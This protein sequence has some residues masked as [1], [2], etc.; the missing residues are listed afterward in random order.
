MRRWRIRR[1]TLSYP[2]G[3]SLFFV[4]FLVGAV[5]LIYQ[6]SWPNPLVFDS[7]PLS[8]IFSDESRLDAWGRWAD[9]ALY[10]APRWVA[11]KTY[12]WIYHAFGSDTYWQRLANTLFHAL[13]SVFL[14]IFFRRLFALVLDEAVPAGVLHPDRL[15]F[16]SAL[17]FALHPVGV[18]A[19]AYLMQRSTVLATLFG[20]VALLSYLEGLT[21]DKKIWLLAAVGFYY[22]AVFSKEHAL[23]VPA[24]ALSMTLLLQR[25]SRSL[26]RRVWLPFFLFAVI[27]L[28]VVWLQVQQGVVGK[29]YEPLVDIMRGGAGEAAVPTDTET[30]Y[31]L[32]VITQGYLFF[33]YLGLW[34]VPYTGWMAIDLR[35]PLA[36]SYFSWPGTFG[37]VAF[38]AFPIVAAW[39]LLQRGRRGLLGFGLLCPWLL[40]ATEL[41]AVR[42]QEPFVLYRSYLWMWGLFAALPFVAYNVRKVVG[43]VLLCGV[44][45]ILPFLTLE[46]LQTFAS[47]LALWEDA[48][49][50]NEALPDSTLGMFRPYYNRGVAYL[51]L[52]RYPEAIRDLD[53]AIE[54]SPTYAVL[55]SDRATANVQLG[56][57]DEALGDFDK[58]VRLDPERVKS[59]VNRGMLYAMLENYPEALSDFDRAIQIN[60][61]YPVTYFNRAVV[62]REIGDADRAME[63]FRVSCDLGFEEACRQ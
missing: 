40:F 1:P 46:R 9:P 19:T 53:K 31:G 17:I 49:E 25:P 42:L 37:F 61:K 26:V 8:N 47:E 10:A 28:G 13:T 4:A 38:C 63:D 52:G 27:A 59:Y 45:L 36:T 43:M 30:L 55:Y 12:Y 3:T 50:K 24:V 39:L 48:V 18:Y 29:V 34:L 11:A 41:A 20:V 58:A 5:V 54:L 22:L 23:M 33:K 32:S 14:Y 51:R 44:A 56:R 16:L 62:Y 60:P 6:G 57:L 7:K 35:F 15:A 21:R 2:A